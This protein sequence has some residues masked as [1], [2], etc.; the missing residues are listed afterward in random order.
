MAPLPPVAAGIWNGAMAAPCAKYWSA[1]VADPNDGAVSDTVGNTAT[2]PVVM[3]PARLWAAAST[4]TARVSVALKSP[5]KARVRVAVL[6]PL[7]TP[8]TCETETF[9]IA[10]TS[11]KL[12]VVTPLAKVACASDRATVAVFRLA[13]VRL[14]G[15]VDAIE[16]P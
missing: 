9:G 12:A 7:V 14:A 11:S 8:D 5:A 4:L 6:P 13:L 1:T 10:V 16:A 15:L 3:S 2:A